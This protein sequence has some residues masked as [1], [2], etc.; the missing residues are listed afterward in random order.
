MA[1]R[2]RVLFIDEI[3]R[4]AGGANSLL[5]LLRHLDKEAYQPFLACPSGPLSEAAQG[6]GV[7]TLNHLFR[8]PTWTVNLFGRKVVAPPIPLCFR[9]WDAHWLTG[10]VRDYD[11][12]MIHS[13]SLSGHV[14]GAL[15]GKAMGIP[16]IWHIR[17]FHSFPSLMFGRACL[18]DQ[19]IFASSAIMDHAF[20]S[21]GHPRACVVHNGI[22]L[23]SFARIPGAYKDVRRE[24]GVALNAG[25]VGIVGRL[26]MGKGHDCFI[27]AA[28][29]VLD[30]GMAAKFMIVGEQY[31]GTEY[32]ANL[33][34][35][36]ADLG[37]EDDIIIT[38]FRKDVARLASA[39]DVFVSAS[40][41]DAHPRVVLEAMA[42]GLPIVGTR[43]GGIVE[44]VQDG[45]SG[46]LVPIRDSQA[47]ANSIIR[48]L[49]DRDLAAQL[50]NNARSR[51]TKHFSAKAYVEKIEKVYESL[52]GGLCD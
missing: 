30:A 1:A 34:K 15:A 35:L 2:R 18:P 46:L 6:M 24:F 48:V 23:D 47:L 36:V 13:N 32:T 37:L 7:K 29:L 25:I 11:I 10:I 8:Y 4:I 17:R 45:S 3:G 26:D 19:V 51:V 31:F 49:S 28:R 16:V 21:E 33:H 39:F 43:S 14:S 41:K 50:G 40:E 22:D 38:G 12:S 44:T 27:R 20:G 9:L 52:L 42:L 5:L